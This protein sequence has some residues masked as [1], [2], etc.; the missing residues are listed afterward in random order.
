MFNPM[1]SQAAIQN[2]ARFPDQKLQQYAAGKPTQPTGQVTPPMAGQELAQRGADRQA[3]QNQA[4]M[5]NDPKNS[6]TIYQELMMKEQMVNQQA[7]AL[8]QKEQQLGMAGAMLAKKARDVAERERGIAAL[9]VRP[10]MFTA[11]DGGIVFRQGGGVQG[12]KGGGDMSA[13][14]A[15][16]FTEREDGPSTVGASGASPSDLMALI[17]KRMESI[18]EAEKTAMLSPEEQELMR[19]KNAQTMQKE[20]DEYARGRGER[21][22]KMAAALRGTAPDLG[23]YL[24]AM[25]AGGPGKTLAETLSRMVPGAAKLRTEQQARDMAAAKFLAEAEEKEAQAD[26]A[27][28]RGQR[29]VADKL[30]RS[31]QNDRIKAFEVKKGA[32]DTGIRALAAISESEDRKSRLADTLA[33]RQ[34]ELESREEIAKR[35]AEIREKQVQINEALALGKISQAQASAANATLDRELRAMRVQNDALLAQ[36]QLGS[37]RAQVEEKVSRDLERNQEYFDASNQAARLR[38]RALDKGS[39][40]AQEKTKLDN[41]NIR[42]NEIEEQTRLRYGGGQLPAP[43]ATAPTSAKPASPQGKIVVNTPGGAFEF[44]TKEQADAYKKAV[45]IK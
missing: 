28:K 19:F 39:L 34:R 24:G 2:P 4:A 29:D 16:G 13:R 33:Q 36:I 37:A 15:E 31:A 43:G 42:L 1:Q 5:Q 9:P 45:G 35:S 40:T 18:D 6:P 32:A 12:F 8:G 23:D 21:Q 38:K 41:L 14:I 22:Q 25:A 17:R 27:E 11:M 44:D 10:D 26:L 7:Q 30:I 3:F 20:Y